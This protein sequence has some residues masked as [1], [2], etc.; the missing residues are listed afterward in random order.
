MFRILL[1]VLLLTGCIQQTPLVGCHD[2]DGHQVYIEPISTRVLQSWNIGV[3]MATWDSVAPTIWYDQAYFPQLHHL[4]REFT[5]W[6]ECGHHALGHTR[7]FEHVVQQYGGIFAVEHSADCYALEH[8]NALGYST[9]KVQAA[10]AADTD[11][12]TEAT[13]NKNPP[14]NHEFSYIFFKQRQE[15]LNSCH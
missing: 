11:L 14:Y 7:S 9:D 6:H 15:A 8:L 2:A 1:L 12:M 10:L 5:K 3:A 4:T 13:I